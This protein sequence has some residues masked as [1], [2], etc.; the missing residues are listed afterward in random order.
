MCSSDCLDENKQVS[1]DLW[2]GVYVLSLEYVFSNTGR[3]N[4]VLSSVVF[5]S[6]GIDRGENDTSSIVRVN[7]FPIPSTRLSVRFLLSR[8]T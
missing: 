4:I 8:A 6:G 2:T 1:S 7:G 3:E 5:Y